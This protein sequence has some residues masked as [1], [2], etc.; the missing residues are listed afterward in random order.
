MGELNALHLTRRAWWGL[1]VLAYIA[2]A[3]SAVLEGDGAFVLLAAP[4]LVFAWVAALWL[5]DR[6]VR[7]GA[8]QPD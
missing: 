1:G 4:L 8:N 3:I 5:V 2:W 6:W 7:K